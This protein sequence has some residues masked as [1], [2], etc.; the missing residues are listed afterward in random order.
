[1]T[2]VYYQMVSIEDVVS[3]N[4]F[5]ILSVENTQKCEKK[6]HQEIFRD[7]LLCKISRWK[8]LSSYVARHAYIISI[9]FK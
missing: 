5:V 8:K 4:N 6:Y 2:S 7:L 9:L 3:Y 1:M